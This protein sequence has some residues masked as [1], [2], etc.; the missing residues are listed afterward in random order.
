MFSPKAGR[1]KPDARSPTPAKRNGPEGYSG[2]SF[3]EDGI[4]HRI[5]KRITT[6]SNRTEKTMW[7][8]AEQLKSVLEHPYHED[9]CFLCAC[10]LD[11]TNRTFEHVI[12]RWLQ[13]R[14]NLWNT[15]LVLLNG[16]TIPYRQLT[17]PC[18]F[19][20][21]NLRLSPLENRISSAITAGYEAVDKLPPFDLFRW[22]AKIY[23]GLQFRELFLAFDRSSPSSGTIL[24]ADFLKKYSIL[25]FWL[26]MSS[27]L[28]EP[29]FCP[30]SVW[31]FPAQVPTDVELQFD[32]KD[33]A[34][35][36]V[37][38]LRIAGVVMIAD[39][40]ENGVHGKITYDAFWKI[41]STPLHP[42]QFDELF[43]RI[44][45]G[46]RRL[47]QETKVVFFHNGDRLSFAINW[48]ST[49]ISGDAMDPWVMGEYAQ[50]LSQI[51]ERPVE[52]LYFPPN[53][54]MTWLYDPQGNIVNWKIGDAHPF[55][56]YPPITG[57]PKPNV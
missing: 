23:L 32:L 2:P 22:L 53:G 40:L 38:A 41:K 35:Y 3:L 33:D 26:Q 20:C 8:P 49:T 21:N 4:Q 10:T 36:G 34:V 28:N 48:S 27:C 57:R 55:A 14:F 9:T 31:V 45:Y 52:E 46:T 12:P 54:V 30:G 1:P 17:I 51:V 7:K 6:Y 18:C 24:S 43:A 16:T 56:V 42:L 25:H 47:R 39:F 44:V 13:E 37:I 29:D 11:E 5:E 15:Q 50:V 19:E